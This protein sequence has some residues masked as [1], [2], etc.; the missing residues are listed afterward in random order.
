MH[1]NPPK[2]FRSE[3]ERYDHEEAA[4]LPQPVRDPEWAEFIAEK[5][6]APEAGKV[7]TPGTHILKTWK[8][9]FNDVKSGL[10]TFE[11]R[12]NDRNFKVGDTLILQEYDHEEQAITGEELTVQVTYIADWNQPEG[13]VVMSIKIHPCEA[14]AAQQNNLTCTHHTDAERKAAGCPVCAAKRLEQGEGPTDEEIEHELAADHQ[15]NGAQT[16]CHRLRSLF[17]P[18]LAKEQRRTDHAK[19]ERDHWN[20]MTLRIEDDLVEARGEIT[21]QKSLIAALNVSDNENARAAREA[22]KLA[23]QNAGFCAELQAKLSRVYRWIEHHNQDGFIDSKS[24]AEN[25]DVIYDRVADQ[26]DSTKQQESFARRS[27]EQAVKQRDELKAQVEI[28]TTELRKTQRENGSI[29]RDREHYSERLEIINAALTAAGWD[30]DKSPLTQV[31][32]IAAKMEELEQARA[33][34]REAGDFL[35]RFG[36]VELK[37]LADAMERLGF[38]PIFEKLRV[39]C[40]PPAVDRKG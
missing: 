7:V 5:P 37:G 38:H 29:Y 12:K 10:K 15:T 19:K 4:P 34:I 25:L 11:I 22:E 13:Q 23:G 27:A 24:H 6:E 1:S 21:R 20:E 33:L 31:E 8:Q 36:W 39:Y 35:G 17:A 3:R 32:F 30:V 40:N 2:A 28:V 14:A 16:L 26:L 18:A 9:Y